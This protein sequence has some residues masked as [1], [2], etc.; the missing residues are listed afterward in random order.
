MFIWQFAFLIIHF[1]VSESPHMIALLPHIHFWSQDLLV[2][3]QFKLQVAWA[4]PNYLSIQIKSL[5]TNFVTGQ[6]SVFTSPFLPA[7][8]FSLSQTIICKHL[9]WCSEHCSSSLRS[10]NVVK[11]LFNYMQILASQHTWYGNVYFHRDN[12]RPFFP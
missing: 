10:V 8:A 6:A 3:L 7:T 4:D 2:N 12:L 5:N 11:P 9:D 1:Y